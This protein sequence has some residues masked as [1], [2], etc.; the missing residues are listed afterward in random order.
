[1]NFGGTEVFGP[2]PLPLKIFSS[3]TPQLR[4]S[5]ISWVLE[6]LV[7]YLV[8]T[9]PVLQLWSPYILIDVPSSPLLLHS[10]YGH[11][12]VCHAVY[13]WTPVNDQPWTHKPSELA[14][15]TAL[16]AWINHPSFAYPNLPRGAGCLRGQLVLHQRGTWWGG[17]R[18]LHRRKSKPLIFA[19]VIRANWKRASAEVCP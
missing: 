14:G 8:H 19:M 13:N 2:Q 7:C 12:M 6:R 4:T 1:M 16:S 10:G 15:K 3:S 17:W 11:S 18:D 5:A 9:C